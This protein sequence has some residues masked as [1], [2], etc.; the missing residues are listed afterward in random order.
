ME[1][2]A[3]LPRARVSCSV[4]VVYHNRLESLDLC[5]N[6][7]LRHT[8]SKIHQELLLK[9]LLKFKGERGSIWPAAATTLVKDHP[10]ELN[11]LLLGLADEIEYQEQWEGLSFV[12]GES[13]KY[14]TERI[15]VKNP[16]ALI[17][18][19]VAGGLRPARKDKK[20]K[21]SKY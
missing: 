11:A 17:W 6:M 18:K 10:V 3:V 7:N 15:V 12:Y 19:L 21:N 13:S 14:N 4:V 20:R 2:L 9:A 16:G 1:N 5:N 8:K